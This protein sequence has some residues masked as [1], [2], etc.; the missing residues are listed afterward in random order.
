MQ[1][2]ACCAFDNL[3]QDGM[4]ERE[5]NMK[6]YM[7]TMLLLMRG[8]ASEYLTLINRISKFTKS[9]SAGKAQKITSNLLK[10]SI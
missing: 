3:N 1:R 7:R 6:R 10:G 4:K 8:L 2:S 5:G 9:F